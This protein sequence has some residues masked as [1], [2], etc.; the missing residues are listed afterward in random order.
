MEEGGGGGGSVGGRPTPGGRTGGEEVIADWWLGASIP[1]VAISGG[2]EGD[3]SPKLM[4]QV[5]YKHGSERQRQ[6]ESRKVWNIY[7]LHTNLSVGRLFTPINKTFFF[8]F[9]LTT[10]PTS[11]A[12][13]LMRHVLL[14]A[15]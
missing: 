10:E 13:V 15:M 7:T 1:L 4:S 2:P 14:N 6:S 8:F 9:L 3:T 12:S 5:Y 11:Q